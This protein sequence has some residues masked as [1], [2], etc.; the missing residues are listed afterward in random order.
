MNACSFVS[1]GSD[2]FAVLRARESLAEASVCE[3][4][5][6]DD[7]PARTTQATEPLWR[8]M[9]IRTQDLVKYGYTDRCE[10]CRSIQTGR[11]RTGICHTEAC[12]QRIVDCMAKCQEGKTRLAEQDRREELYLAARVETAD[13]QRHALPQKRSAD[14]AEL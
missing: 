14:V 3:D 8:R 5:K 6:D 11:T 13:R 4:S 10:A 1:L 7:A 2:A 9:Y 12:R